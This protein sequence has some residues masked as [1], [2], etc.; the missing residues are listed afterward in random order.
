MLDTPWAN[1]R[2]ASHP[3]VPSL[4]GDLPMNGSDTNL[5]CPSEREEQIRKFQEM[6]KPLGPKAQGHDR[7][8]KDLEYWNRRRQLVVKLVV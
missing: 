5:E 3:R 6:L 2:I 4:K 7:L 8:R 1:I